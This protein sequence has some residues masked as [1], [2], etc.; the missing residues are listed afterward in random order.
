VVVSAA[1]LSVADTIILEHSSRIVSEHQGPGIPNYVGA[2]A[3][4]PA[5]GVG[6]VPSK[7]DNI[8][9]GELRGGAGMTFDQTVRAIT[10]KIDLSNNSEQLSNRVDHD[11][12]SVAGVSAFD[13]YG[14][15][16]FTS[17]EGNRQV[18]LI[19]VSTAIEIG[20]F[21]TGRAP[22]GLAVSAD[23]TRLYVHNFT[24]RSVGVYDIEDV[25]NNGSTF[26]EVVDTVDVVSNDRLNQTVLRGKQLFYDARDDRLA[27]LDYMSCASC[28]VDGEHDGRVWDFTGLGE[29]LRNTITLKGRAGTGHGIL[30]WTGNFDEIQDFEGQIREF[31]GGSGLMNDSDFAAT[32]APL[33]AAKAGLSADLDALA[34]YMES[35][36]Q[37][38]E[39]P[40]RNTDGTMTAAAQNGGSLFVSKGCATCHAGAVFTDSNSALLHDVGTLMT[41]SGQRLGATLTGLDTPTLLGVWRTAPYLHDGSAATLEDAIAAHTSVNVTA[42]EQADLASYLAQLDDGAPVVPPVQVLPPVQPPAAATNG[43]SN[44]LSGA[45][46]AVDGSLNEWNSAVSFGADPNDSNG[47]NTIDWASAT[48][49]HNDT[50]FYIGY[51]NHGAVTETWGH[52]IYIDVDGDINTG[53]TGFSSELPVGADYLIE[54]RVVQRYTGAGTTWSW[55]EIGSAQYAINSDT[56][57]LAVPRSLLGDPST[58]RLYFNGNN[59]AVGGSTV[60]YYPDGVADAAQANIDRYFTYTIANIGGNSPPVA[61]AQN[62]SVNTG[63]QLAVVLTGSDTDQDVLNYEIVDRPSNGTL[64]GN[65]PALTYTP[66]PGHL[67]ADQ[68]TFTVR[69]AISTSAPAVVSIMTIGGVPNNETTITVDGSLAEWA[70]VASFGSDPVDATGAG[71]QIDWREGWV[72]HDA[73]DFYF[74]YENNNPVTVSWGYGIYIDTD[75][76][77]ATGFQNF[78]GSYPI[79]ADYV[80]EANELLRYTGTGTDWSWSLVSLNELQISGNTAEIRIPRNALGNP[81][82]LRLF[83]VGEN[84]ANNGPTVDYYPDTALDVSAVSRTF[85][86]DTGSQSANAAPVATA[87][88]LSLQQGASITV[89]L[90]ATDANGDT[91]SYQVTRQPVSGTLTGAAPSLLYTP[92]GGFSGADSFEFR[93]YDG[94]VTSDPAVVTLSVIP[95]SP[96]PN[97]SNFVSALTI[98]GSL[99]D[100]AGVTPLAADASDINSAA[101]KIDFRQGYIAHNDSMLYLAY[102]NDVPMSQLTWGHAV[103]IGTDDA[104]TTGFRGF[105]SELPVAADFLLEGTDLYSYSGSGTNWL[106]TYVATVNAQQV[107]TIAEIALSR[108]QL[109]NPSAIEIYWRGQNEAVGGNGVDFYP[110]AAG[111]PTAPVLQRSFRY[112]LQP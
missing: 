84:A 75:N 9:A 29:G 109:G 68:F 89:N 61:L 22:Q 38:D 54:G 94:T 36:E 103:F 60:D 80:I 23:G 43:V 51:Q 3:I 7:Q 4:A 25:V 39:S 97:G 107:G 50:D 65:L 58:L 56:V 90:T 40:W 48:I 106:W 31:A 12:A 108:A 112:V 24:D 87:Q 55:V 85:T 83:Y 81:D 79:G 34:A 102:Q 32:E 69:D 44:P 101:E 72:A 8:L 42:A 74:A 46:I 17:L 30:H 57:E 66:A 93:A 1:D 47:V 15:T 41:E 18:A 63:Q 52:G 95:A 11:N 28:H 104:N 35:L 88:S 111:N 77:T 59:T 110:D 16:L 100:W 21:D 78:D 99:Q 98:D 62:L 45:T 6:W 20:R 53:F 92:N 71:D 70:G 5:G 10:S 49:V 26:V 19:D 82:R 14:V 73:T 2:V 13:P 86:Y 105:S 91:L 64:T 67:G 37:V 33:G 27:G 96:A 76:S